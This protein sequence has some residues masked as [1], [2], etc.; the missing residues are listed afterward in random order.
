M[1]LD[2]ITLSATV[3]AN[4][5]LGAVVIARNQRS[6]Q[7]R[8][9]LI[10]ALAVVAWS[11]ANY[12][13]DHLPTQ[14]A[15]D[16]ATRLTFVLG[17]WISLSILF[18]S[19]F[20]PR[21]KS[22]PRRESLLFIL[23]YIATAIF[24]ASPLVT[25]SVTRNP[26]GAALTPGPLYF[27]FLVMFLAFIAAA[28]FNFYRKYA[29]L[30]QLERAQVKLISLGIA[31]SSFIGLILN[32]VLPL[33]VGSWA[34]SH[35]GP[36]ITVFFV[37]TIAYTI[38]R[39]R[40]MDIRL[41]VARSVAYTL[42]L[43]T[44]GLLYGFAAF[45]LGS[46]LFHD[47]QISLAQEAY[48]V[49]LAVVLAFTFQPLRRFF[50]RITNNIFYRDRY[51]PQEVVNNFSKILVSELNLERILK[52]ALTDLCESLHVQFGQIIVYNSGRVYRIEHYGPLPR[53]LM[54][55]PELAKLGKPMLI[56]DEL[57]DGERK[58]L[59]EGHGVRISIMLRTR[60]EFVGYLLLGDKLSGDI[61]SS[62]DIEV[63]EIISKE[64][65][66]AI[67]NAKAY[68]EIQEFTVTL[69]GRI[70]RATKRLRVAN[71][72]LKELDRAKDEFIS[73]ASHQLRTP[74]TTIKGY[75]SMMLEGDAGKLTHAQK[76]FVGYAFGSSERMVN[77]I[78][79]LL[80]VSRLQAG[81]FLIQTKPTDL[82]KMITDEIRQLEE[83]AKS[84]HISLTFE[85]PS[86]PLPLVEIDENKTRQVI[87]NFIDNAIYYTQV[88]GVT[89]VLQQAGTRVRFEVR[90][91]G[92][93]VPPEA[94]KKLFTKFYRAG[95]AQ[96]VRPDGTGLGLYLAKRVVEDQGGT[97]I[98]ES[99]EGEG[100]TFGFELP[101]KPVGQPGTYTSRP[102]K[103]KR[104]HVSSASAK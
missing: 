9:F 64:L 60:E 100:S 90:D 48:N 59:L 43:L 91:T 65:A 39:H 75:L 6:R 76:E 58:K 15:T 46:F 35:F 95:N 42:L 70:D 53:R 101:Y 23:A 92:I 22:M 19:R 45:V 8:A 25:A 67:L 13:A 40:F 57:N 49:T 17:A 74:L 41:V 62:Q 47:S 1:I 99:V 30:T 61:Y 24:S 88:G 84:K 14:T 31:V 37:G 28:F 10:L 2:I 82:V 51:D 68:A 29:S 79:D 85:L 33:M 12:T 54:I 78:S 36:V 72:H 18:F 3:L 69:Q 102:S 77:L 71:R 27:G 104:E 7:A 20:F 66:V 96:T 97:I 50:E 89:V 103:P 16:L 73:M 87:M 26:S 94:R 44:L 38:I 21:E 56:A 98:F 52:H 55:A 93:G 80:N 11:I 4:L 34:S 83:H 81:R 86:E 63:L 5:F 32:V